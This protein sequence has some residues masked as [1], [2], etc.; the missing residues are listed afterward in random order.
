[1]L[2]DH[3]GHGRFYNDPATADFQCPQ[4]AC[5]TAPVVDMGA[6]EFIAGDYDRDGDLDMDDAAVLE[7]CLS[8]PAV[9]L[10]G[11]CLK[12]DLDRDGDVDLTDFG[13]FQ[14]CF[15]GAGVAVDPACNP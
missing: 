6:Y 3:D 13:V 10:V 9:G 14:R 15:S 5:N 4:E 1:M 11:D 8:G 2:V 12:A 7:A